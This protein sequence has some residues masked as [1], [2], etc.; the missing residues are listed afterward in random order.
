MLG[1]AGF[2]IMIAMTY[3]TYKTARNT[4][5]N[6]GLWALTAFGVGFTFQFVIP[7]IIGMVLGI[8]LVMQGTTDPIELQSKILGPATVLG[9][10]C[11]VLSVV[12]M[13]LVFRHV[14]K[15]PDVLLSTEVP[16][17]PEFS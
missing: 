15:V 6:A 11:L 1:I 16:P 7:F 8:V 5:R 9:I 13:W 2:V 14:S 4:G 10:I 12:G 3:Q 17:P